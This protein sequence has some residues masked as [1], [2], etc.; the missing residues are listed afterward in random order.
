MSTPHHRRRRR[1]TNKT[2]TG[3]QPAKAAK[4][5]PGKRAPRRGNT[6]PNGS[7]HKS[8]WFYDVRQYALLTDE[9][10]N[11]LILQLPKEYDATAANTWTLP[12]G[13]LEPTD[14]PGEGLLREITEETGLPATLVGPCGVARWT[15]RN[16]KKLGIF[17]RA[18]TAGEKPKLKLSNEH[19]RAIWI[20]KE[21]ISDFPFHRTE[22]LEIVKKLNT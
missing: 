14:E 4:S 13:K 18:T 2:A 6:N 8:R 10:G 1:P 12:G 20:G 22:M 21:E 9:S 15:T 5:P 17:Y 19:Q 11:L 3:E 7:T 16:S